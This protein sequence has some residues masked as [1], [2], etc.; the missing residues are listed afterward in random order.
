MKKDFWRM[1][2]TILK[3]DRFL[4]Q[5]ELANAKKQI[6]YSKRIIQKL[7]R[8]SEEEV[9]IYYREVVEDKLDKSTDS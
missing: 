9:K 5:K 2:Y 4:H 8:L 7:D 1:Q 6:A 3:Y